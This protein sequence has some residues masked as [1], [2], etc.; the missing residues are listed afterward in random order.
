M[1]LQGV[2]LT[3]P[4]AQPRRLATATTDSDGDFHFSYQPRQGFDYSL[5]VASL[6]RIEN[7]S[8]SPVFGDL[9]AP[10]SLHLGTVKVGS[11]VTRRRPRQAASR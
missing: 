7:S 1:R 6:S 8:L 3:A 5:A 10:T 9:L 11:N 2:P 4:S